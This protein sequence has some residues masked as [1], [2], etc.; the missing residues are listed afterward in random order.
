MPHRTAYGR[1]RELG[2]LVVSETTPADELPTATASEPDRA[3]RDAAG[4]HPGQPMGM[5]RPREGWS[6]WRSGLARR[7]GGA[8]VAGD[9]TVGSACGRAPDP[10]TR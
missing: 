5:A 1:A 8:G 10:R 7:Q 9:A 6:A 3:G 4:A 2:C